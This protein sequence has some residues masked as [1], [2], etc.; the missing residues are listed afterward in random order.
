MLALDN[1]WS[2]GHLISSEP[3]I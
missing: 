1:E 3:S 2:Y